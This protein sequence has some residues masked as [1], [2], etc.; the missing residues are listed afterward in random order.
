V[1]F[2][3]SSSDQIRFLAGDTIGFTWSQFGVIP[4]AALPAND[5]LYCEDLVNPPAVGSDFTLQIG[6]YGNRFYS[7][8]AFYSPTSIGRHITPSSL[9]VG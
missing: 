6:R 4:F 9:F 2:Q 7:I 8:Q 3:L 1:Q 5:Y